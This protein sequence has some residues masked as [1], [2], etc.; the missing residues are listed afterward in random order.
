MGPIRAENG[1]NE[2]SGN[3]LVPNALVF[4]ILDFDIMIGST[5]I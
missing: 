5:D 2:G 3:F 1:Q 4:P